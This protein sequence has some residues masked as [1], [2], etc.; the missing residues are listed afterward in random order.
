M[1]ELVAQ[2]RGVTFEE[3]AE[4]MAREGL[5]NRVRRKTGKVPAD[6]AVAWQ[7]W[8]ELCRLD[9]SLL[10]RDARRLSVGQQQRV[11]LARALMGGSDVLLLDEPTSAL[12]PPT[13]EALAATFRLLAKQRGLTVLLATHDL[14]LAR[15]LADRVLFL[16]G[17][18][19]V[20]EGPA[21]ALLSAPRTSEL[22]A[23]LASEGYR[24]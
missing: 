8:L 10:D 12:D 20:E 6:D 3:A 18:R 7:Q 24:P 1:I 9:R 15:S 11:C 2:Q 19:V 21:T 13:V 4:Q 22:Q 5:A 16:V 17:G 14:G 23:F